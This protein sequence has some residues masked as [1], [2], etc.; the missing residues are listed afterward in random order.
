MN[1]RIILTDNDVVS[2]KR[3]D[4]ITNSP[5]SKVHEILSATS[6]KVPDAYSNWFKGT[7]KCEVLTESSGWVKGK[8]RY[9]IEFIPSADEIKALP[10]SNAESTSTE[11]SLDDL[12][13]Q[14]NI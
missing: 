9:V 8:I 4:T 6:E 11:E 1:K 10:P 5:T 7:L 13:K 2:M 3:E 14:L 12:R